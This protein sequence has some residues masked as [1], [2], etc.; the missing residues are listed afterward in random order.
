[1][2]RAITKAP[3]QA[4]K[5]VLEKS[6]S[7]GLKDNLHMLNFRL[8]KHSTDFLDLNVWKYIC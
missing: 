2:M 7:D 1:M 8:M 4:D 5:T 6:H 3:T